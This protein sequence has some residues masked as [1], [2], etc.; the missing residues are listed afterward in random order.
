M[1]ENAVSGAYSRRAHEYAEALGRISATA[2]AD[3]DTIAAWALACGGPVVDLGCGPGHWT[4]YLD[5]LGAKASG[6]DPSQAL[7]GIARA[8]HPN[9]G[10]AVGTAADV[11]PGGAA[12][13]LA[14]YSLIHVPPERLGE[15]LAAVRR[16]LRPGGRLLAGFFAGDAVAPFDHAVTTAWTWT[17]EWITERLEEAGLIVEQVRRRQDPG[18]RE[19]GEVWA[20]LP[21]GGTVGRRVTDVIGVPGWVLSGESL[22]PAITDL[23]AFRAGLQEDPLAGAIEALWTGRVA[24]ARVL[25]HGAAQP[26][27]RT[28]AL[29]AD[30]DRRSGDAGAAVS[31]L[32]SLLAEHEE[33]R[34]EPVLRQH[35]GKALLAAGEVD[36]ARRELRLAL[37]ARLEAGADAGLL[38][39]S[40]QALA[41]TG[42]GFGPRTPTGPAGTGD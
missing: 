40:R 23:P 33:D 39:S 22:A 1:P 14:W 28:R 6:V 42:L 12:G 35:L 3:R 24:E 11:P 4:A 2:P 26:S 27:V 19:H 16:L 37:E 41:R 38:A 13:V 34:W 20:V 21:S 10:F 7:I 29:L 18:A 25:L 17:P 36:A 8:E 32:R 9:V 5:A 31:A 30:C 15:E